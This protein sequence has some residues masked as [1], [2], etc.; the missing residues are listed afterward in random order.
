MKVK[1]IP[2]FENLNTQSAFSIGLRIN[3]FELS[4]TVLTPIHINENYLQPQNDLML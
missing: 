1:D 3:V 2:Q 4:G